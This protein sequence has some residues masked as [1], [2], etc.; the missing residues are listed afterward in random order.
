MQMQP[1]SLTIDLLLLLWVYKGLEA[2]QVA[3]RLQYVT[4]GGVVLRQHVHPP[5]CNL[6]VTLLNR[7]VADNARSITR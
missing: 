3:A 4:S 5:Y 1:L 7:H 2:E 6:I